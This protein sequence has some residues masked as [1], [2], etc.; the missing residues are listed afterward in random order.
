MGAMVTRRPRW[1]EQDRQHRTSGMDWIHRSTRMAIYDR[2]GHRC[3]RCGE[4]NGLSLDHIHDDIGNVPKNL[5]TCCNACNGERGDLPIVEFDPAY[6]LRAVRQSLL[7]L[8]RERGRMLAKAKW[9]RR[10]EKH[11]ETDRVYKAKKRNA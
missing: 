1:P 6:A 9:P 7:P 4:S 10:F 2:D 5:V 3:V 8:D 11:R